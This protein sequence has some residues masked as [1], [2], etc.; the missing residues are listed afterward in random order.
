MCKNEALKEYERPVYKNTHKTNKNF[1]ITKN[2][3]KP[4]L[5]EFLLYQETP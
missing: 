3:K 5:I 1:K 2:I 4:L